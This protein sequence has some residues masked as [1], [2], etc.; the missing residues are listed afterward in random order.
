[1]PNFQ[2]T[3]AL[4]ILKL[5]GVD[6]PFIFVSG[7]I[8][9]DRA[10]EAMKNG[11]HD[12]VIKGNLKR[13]PPVVERELREVEVRQGRKKAEEALMASEKKYRNI[14]ENALVGIYQTALDG[15]IVYANNALSRMFEFESPEEMMSDSV[16]ARYKNPG[17][18]E[19]LIGNLKKTGKVTDFELEVFTKDGKTKNVIISAKLEGDVLSGMVIDITERKQTEEQV[20]H[21]AY[22]DILTDLPNRLMLRDNIDRAISAARRENWSFALC[23]MNLSRF[24][25]INNTLGHQN[26]DIVLQEVARRLQDTL[27]EADTVAHMGGDDFAILM[28]NIGADSV[29]KMISNIT[30]TLAK[31]F[32]LDGLSLDI[33]YS[34]GISIFPGHGEDA[35]TMIRRAYIAL[36]EAKTTESGFGI[37]TPEFDKFITEHLALMGELRPAIELNQLFLLYQPKVDI[38]TG[39]TL[40]VEALV[41]WQHPKHGVIPPDQFISLAEKTGL[42]RQ[43]TFWVLRES[44]RQ[45]RSWH[46]A[47][48][49]V[50]IAVNLSVRSLHAQL[51]LDQIKGLLA[52]WGIPTSLLRLEITESII[53]QNPEIAME[54]ITELT[55]MGIKFS[56][57]DFGTG[58][59]SLSYLQRLPVDEIKID[60]SFV[61]NMMKD[62][63]SNTIVDSI[64]EL[65][66]SLGLKVVAEGVES[67]EILD[68]LALAGCDIAQGYYIS[69]PIPHAE[70]TAWLNKQI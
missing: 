64:I 60:K 63:N 4:E 67:K 17:D 7:T 42:I 50:S 2:G 8:G 58:Y 62:E 5:K 16:L 24:K 70:I 52:T 6:I 13:L 47:G 48:F 31:P 10:V 45:S 15:R 22:Y 59:S 21:L 46:Q 3:E 65:G 34:A 43:L 9:E 44:M 41:R 61:M 27:G 1:M 35:D 23:I 55:K 49:D 32:S 57:D 69:K 68:R 39:R 12:Y 26:G 19:A 66:H 56:I 30:S 14:A 53:M 51:I 38:R 54:I 36:D 28:T 29:P 33:S 20:R 18:R 11:A 25:D 40:G 37:Y